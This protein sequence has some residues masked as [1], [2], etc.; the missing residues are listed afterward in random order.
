MAAAALLVILLASTWS[1][2]GGVRRMVRWRE[3]RPLQR[4]DFTGCWVQTD[5]GRIV[6]EGLAD[7]GTLLFQ[8]FTIVA[9]G[10]TIEMVVMELNFGGAGDPRWAAR[11]AA[12]LKAEVR[13]H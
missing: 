13:A 1:L 9:N 8:H 7:P 6:A 12:G 5:R 2:A 3:H 11:D 4:W 10:R